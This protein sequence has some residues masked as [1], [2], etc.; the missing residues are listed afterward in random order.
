MTAKPPE[1]I[2]QLAAPDAA[3]RLAAAEALYSAGCALA[4]A[5]TAA[6]RNDP[7]FAALLTGRR[8]VGIA[9]TPENFHRIRAAVGS[10]PLAD[11]PPDQDA[12]EFELHVGAA[13]LDILTTR[14]PKA[15]G[16]IAHFLRKFGEGLQQV[17]YFVADVDRATELLR[18]RLGIQSIYPRTRSGADRSRINFFLASAPDNRKVL[19]ELVESPKA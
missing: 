6:W 13:S 14:D 7:D 3:S 4:D 10:P 9:V 15:G 12:L 2:S 17:E 19:I 16:A 18:V 8:T 1:F 11:V 5:A